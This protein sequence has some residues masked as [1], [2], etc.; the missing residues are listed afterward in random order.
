[1]KHSILLI[2]VFLCFLL[3]SLPVFSDQP[4]GVR[5]DE[6]FEGSLKEGWRWIR[7][8]P[9]AQ[10]WGEDGLEIRMLPFA[11][12]EAKNVLLRTAPQRI[13]GE[14]Y[15][16]QLT[17]ETL[18]PFVQQYQ[19]VGIYFTQNDGTICKFV[20]ERIDGETYVFPGKVPIMADKLTLRL[21]VEGEN[22]LGEYRLDGETAFSHAFEGKIPPS[23]GEEQVGI[24]TWHGPADQESWVRFTDFSIFL[25]GEDQTESGSSLPRASA[26]EALPAEMG[27]RFLQKVKDARMNLHSVMVLKNGKV[28]FEKWLRQHSPQKNHV[29]WS[30]SKTFTSMA[31]GFAISEGKLS[32]QDQVISFFPDDLPNEISDN[33]KELKIKDLLSM[34]VGHDTD[35]T[36]AIR[37]EKASWEQQFLAFPIPHQPGTKFVYNSIATYMLSSILQKVTGEKL[38][39]YLTPRLFVPL[40]ITGATWESN[41][42]GVNIG[43]WGL[44]VKTEDMAKLGQFLLQKGKWKGEQLLP[45]SWIEEATTM[46]I[47]QKPDVKPEESNSDWEQG[48]CYQIWRSRHNSFRADGMGGQFIL[49]LPEQNA[50]VVLTANIGNMQEEVNLVWDILLPAL[51]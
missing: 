12:R 34:S 22:V 11:D 44:Y 26:E 2:I 13:A 32:V 19:Q 33:L 5:F 38:I 42:E 6:P 1:M 28:I 51:K 43:G 39:D 30:V 9:D 17:L 18:S 20:R 35:P 50:V 40:G 10:K 21:T 23:L 49:V 46:K 8:V 16:V 4:Q 37:N 15:T 27:E 7:E 48:Y 36:V 41:S 24:Q 3:P 14:P 47:L 29:M 25:T 31:I 45:E